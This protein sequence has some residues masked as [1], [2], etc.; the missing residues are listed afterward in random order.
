MTAERIYCRWCGKRNRTASSWEQRS[1]AGV[2]QRL[3]VRCA[4][5]RLNNPW[6]ALLAMRKVATPG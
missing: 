3:C 6:S 2:W 4:N 1:L 5:Q